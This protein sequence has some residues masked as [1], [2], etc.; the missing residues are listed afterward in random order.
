MYHLGKAESESD[1]W[2]WLKEEA[3]ESLSGIGR[4]ETHDHGSHT[5]TQPDRSESHHL[6][7]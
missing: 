4:P 6:K 2:K 1:R 7:K 5:D 3:K